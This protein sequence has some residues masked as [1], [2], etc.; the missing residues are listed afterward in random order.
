MAA[1]SLIIKDVNQIKQELQ[2]IRTMVEALRTRLNALTD[3]LQEQAESENPVTSFKDLEGVWSGVNLSYEAI[4]SAE[5]QIL[6]TL[7]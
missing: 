4:K 7:P 3:R 6:E 5:F 2:T 1:P